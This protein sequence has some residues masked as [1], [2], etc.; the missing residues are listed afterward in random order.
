M[1]QQQIVKIDGRDFVLTVSRK[2]SVEGLPDSKHLVLSVVDEKFTWDEAMKK[3][4][5]FGA[6]NNYTRR[7]QDKIL[8]H[9]FPNMSATDRSLMGVEIVQNDN[10]SAERHHVHAHLICAP[11]KIWKEVLRRTV[12]SLI[13]VSPASRWDLFRAMLGWRKLYKYKV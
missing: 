6:L 3:D 2:S 9:F 5:D 13:D 11:R 10:C 12:D 7:N 1:T 4:F 8:S